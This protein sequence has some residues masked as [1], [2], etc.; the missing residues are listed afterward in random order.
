[1]GL[2]SNQARFLS[3]SSRQIDLEHRMQQ[4]CQRRLRLSNELETVA[5]SYNNAISNRKMF[6]RS[7]TDQSQD[8]SI[9][10]LNAAGYKV[11]DNETDMIIGASPLIKQVLTQINVPAGYTAITSANE[12]ET[13]ING[14]LNGNYILMDN[15]DLSSLGTRASSLIGGAFTGT[16]DGNGY[17]ISNLNIVENSAKTPATAVH[18]GLFSDVSGDAV[19][20]NLVLEDF[21]IKSTDTNG[22][23]LDT[24]RSNTT[25]SLAGWVNSPNAIIDNIAVINT[26]IN[27]GIAPN[28]LTAAGGLVGIMTTGSITNCM[29]SGTVT[30]G[31]FSGGLVGQINGGNIDICNSSAT[32]I[33]WDYVGGLV[34]ESLPS[35]AAPV[36]SRSY[37][38]GNVTGN[39]EVGGLMGRNNKATL[40]DCYTTGN[41]TGAYN[42]GGIAGDTHQSASLINCYTTGDVTGPAASTAALVGNSSVDGDIYNSFWTGN[43][44]T[45][46]NN[47][48]TV[49][50]SQYVGSNSEITNRAIS[51]GW[52]ADPNEFPTT[53]LTG[54]GGS[55]NTNTVPPTLYAPDGY[56]W[57][58]EMIEENLRSGRFSLATD[59]D[60]FTQNP[61]TIEGEDYEKVDWR[62]ASEVADV[63]YTA[64]D[65]DAENRYSRNVTD[66]NSQDKMLQLE[67][68]SVETEYKSITSEREAVKKILE[69]NAQSSFKYFS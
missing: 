28:M 29:S 32:V 39:G 2:S 6:V 1:M 47:P 11:I 59:A 7:A 8:L 22:M 53:E 65:L 44:A 3:L 33:G 52:G 56:T 10:N 34:G 14:N 31:N 35:G 60:E 16:L 19:I 45:A 61:T 23:D 51:A 68:A 58:P 64:D 12:F 15:I 38:T 9:E 49:S 5:T 30:A 41:V 25:G 13:L 40:Q 20:K 63:L 57:T 4:I 18:T 67:Q 46:T 37:T 42:V 21:N 17:K 26:S 36:V 62:T 50:N 24:C 54:S 69:T 43:G 27:E 48:R 66:I 55:W